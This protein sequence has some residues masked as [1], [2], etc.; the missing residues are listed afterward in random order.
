MRRYDEYGRAR[1]LVPDAAVLVPTGVRPTSPPGETD[2]AFVRELWGRV[3]GGDT[4]AA[5]EEALA[6]DAYRVRTLLAHWLAEGATA[7]SQFA[8]PAP[9]ATP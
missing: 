5:C 2:G 8:P 1:A 6:A 4:A 7:V 9:P 3:K